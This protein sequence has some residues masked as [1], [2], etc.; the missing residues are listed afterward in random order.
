[1]RVFTPN[2]KTQSNPLWRA[3]GFPS[4][5]G[6]HLNAVLNEGLPI[7]VVEKIQDWSMFAKRDI[8]RITGIQMRNYSRR[9][10]NKGKFTADE[11]QRI[12]RFVRV[13]DCAVD[14]FDGDKDKATQWMKRPV[15]G[16]GYVTPES[17]LDTESGALDVIN[18]IGRI[19]HGVIS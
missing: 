11:S 13:M 12:A 8:L 19:E 9:R 17:M 1:M 7:T 15:R 4:S 10:S 2:H 5:N 16:L 18:L 6:P 14:L 3:V